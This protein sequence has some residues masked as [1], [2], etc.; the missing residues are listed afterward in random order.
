MWIWALLAICI[1]LPIIGFI[2]NKIRESK[3]P[4]DGHGKIKHDEDLE[5]K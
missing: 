4:R 3:S 1:G 2:I 5:K